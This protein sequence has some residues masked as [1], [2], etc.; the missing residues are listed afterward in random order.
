MA[1]SSTF[2]VPVSRST[3]AWVPRP[4]HPTMPARSFSFP[5]ARTIH[6]LAIVKAVAPAPKRFLR[7]NILVTPLLTSANEHYSDR[8]VLHSYNELQMLNRRQLL[9]TALG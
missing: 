6:G 5:A 8:T 7:D 2:S 9:R 3:T 1:T 4:P